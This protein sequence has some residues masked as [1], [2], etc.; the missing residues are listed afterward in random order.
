MPDVAVTGIDAAEKDIPL[1]NEGLRQDGFQTPPSSCG[2][3]WCQPSDSDKDPEKERLRREPDEEGR[4]YDDPLW[5]GKTRAD[6]Q[7][8]TDLEKSNGNAASRN[9][10]WKR[11]NRYWKNALRGAEKLQDAGLELRLHLN[12]A[13]GYTKQSKTEKALDHCE[14]ALRERVKQAADAELHAKVHYRA[15]E[16]HEAAGEVTKAIQS[17]KAAIEVQPQNP[18]ARKRLSKL[19]ALEADRRKR[20]RSIFQG[21]LP[22]TRKEES[23]VEG[24]GDRRQEEENCHV[25]GYAADGE[26]GVGPDGLTAQQRKI[27]SNLTDRSA[28][29][30]LLGSLGIDKEGQAGSDLAFPSNMRIGSEMIF[31]PSR[32]CRFSEEDEEEKEA[33]D[34]DDDDDADKRETGENN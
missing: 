11:A 17:M 3:S 1:L 4:Y 7:Y 20:E 9:G 14:R 21:I 19:K 23:Q 29:S 18:E 34:D 12:L 30:R 5:Y 26:E 32:E 6:I 15:S 16:A 8:A 2:S 27:A 28:S 24:D 13:L 25:E 22:K 33:E 31:L 10:D